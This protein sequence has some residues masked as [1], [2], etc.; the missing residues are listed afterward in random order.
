MTVYV[1]GY[2]S[3]YEGGDIQAVYST[4]ELAEAS[5]EMRNQESWDSYEIFE[6]ELDADPNADKEDVDRRPRF[7]P[8]TFQQHIMNETFK[9]MS[10][11]NFLSE[12]PLLSTTRPLPVRTG[13]EIKFFT[14]VK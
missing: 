2:T 5:W 13:N 6:L 9:R 12:S 4:R 11:S 1:V 3:A 14:Y 8:K 10:L 7:G